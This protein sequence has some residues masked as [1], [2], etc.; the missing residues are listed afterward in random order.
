MHTEEKLRKN[1]K[2]FRIIQIAIILAVA[3]LVAVCTWQFLEINKLRNPDHA[4]QQAK[5][6]AAALKDKVAKL[7]QLPEEEAT[8]ATVQDAEKLS[9]QE[10][11]KDAQNGD[12]VLIFTAAKKAII[13]RPDSNKIINSG[14]IVINSVNSDGITTPE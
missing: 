3:A 13:Y 14:P 8:V 10:F 6:D 7:M 5:A 4:S 2:K 11:F 1:P 9:G 12:K